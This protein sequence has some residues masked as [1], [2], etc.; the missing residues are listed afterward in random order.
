MKATVV[1][2]LLLSSASA[3]YAIVDKTCDEVMNV[4]YKDLDEAW[5]GLSS[6]D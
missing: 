1:I 2:S 4:V 3:G 5:A 6:I